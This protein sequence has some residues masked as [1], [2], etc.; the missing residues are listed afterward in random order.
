MNCQIPDLSWLE[1]PEIFRVNRLDA[2]SDHRFYESREDIHKEEMPLRQYLNGVWKFAFSKAPSLRPADFYEDGYDDSGFGEISVPGHIETQGYDKCQYVNTMYPWDGHSELRPPKIDWDDDPVGSYVKEFDLEGDLRGKR[3]YL[4]FQGVES[5]MYV[6]LNGE[7]VGYAEDSFTPSEFDVSRIIKATGNRLCVEV[8][9]RSSASWIEDQDFFRFSGIFRDV[10]LYA[11]PKVHVQD[12]FVK[13]QLTDEYKNGIL[14]AELKLSA[15]DGVDLKGIQVEALLR[16]SSG[17]GIW[18]ETKKAEESLDFETK[19]LNVNPWSAEIPYCYTLYISIGYPPLNGEDDPVIEIVPQ[20]VGFK[21]IEI[22]DSVIFLNG[23]RVLFHGINRHEFDMNRGRA[24]TKED[25]L[26][27]I[28]FMK[29]H[30][31]NAVRTCHYPDQSLWYELCDKYGIYLIDETDLESHGSWSKMNVVDPSWNVPG[32]LPEWEQCVLDRAESMLERDKNHPS[33]C[34]WSC[35][36]E[37]Y[38]GEDIASMSGFFKERDPSR[39]VQYEGVFHNREFDHIS[40]TESR[41]YAKPAEIEEYL[42]DD[43]MKPFIS[44]EY[45]HAMGNSLGGMKHYIDLEDK[46]PQYSGGFIWDFIDQALLHEDIDGG[47]VLGYGGDFT[48]RPT[49]Y[50]FCG[51]GI[52]YAFREPSP[53]AMEVRY[54]Y[55]YLDIKPDLGEVEIRNKYLFKDTSDLRFIYQILQDGEVVYMMDLKADVNP[56][57][58]VKIPV[59]IG[60]FDVDTLKGEVVIQVSA[61]LRRGTLW[62]DAGFETAFGEYVLPSSK[63]SKADAGDAD[64]AHSAD[65]ALTLSMKVVHGDVNIGVHGQGFEVLFSKADAGIVSLC[66]DGKEWIMRPPVPAYWRATTDNDRGNGF[67]AASSVWM[68]QDQFP[69]CP[70]KE[71]CVLEEPDKVTV[72][73]TFEISTDPPAKTEIS[74]TVTPDGK[75]YVREHFYGKKGLPQL[76]LFGMRWKLYP[77][78]DH[79]TYYGLGPEENYPDRDNGARLGIFDGTAAKNLS[80]YL[81]PQEC[82]CRMGVRWLEISDKDGKALKFTACGEPFAMSVLPYTPIELENAMHEDELPLSPHYTIVSILARQRGVGGDDSWGAP[83]HPEYCI[84]AEEDIEFE[85]CVSRG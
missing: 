19:I 24:V 41:M 9:K 63:E 72:T 16:D 12:L 42:K 21:T 52:V 23:K 77:E 69:V 3:V 39:L 55:Q 82:G 78:N 11:V 70:N 7:F 84:S 13:A 14:R 22:K 26:W 43:P 66:F 45:M 51:N 75:I 53:K 49:D 28:R 64:K 76:P 47:K 38:A 18:L 46:Y 73:Y 85:Y 2:H 62:A 79:F 67:G 29:Q 58:T 36:N 74:Y 30:N 27:D 61:V 54:M 65:E 80:H 57:E 17:R 83:V 6:W 37:S 44:I 4:S 56:G 59:E 60:N 10:Y 8:Y 32:S 5:A 34:I 68:A 35:G 40:D 81:K 71:I 50:N 20:T 31:I 48:D 1:D 33:V 15:E 25:M